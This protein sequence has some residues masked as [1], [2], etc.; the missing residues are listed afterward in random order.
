MRQWHPGL[1][2]G[3]CG[4]RAGEKEVVVAELKPHLAGRGTIIFRFHCCAPRAPR[5]RPVRSQLCVGA[6]QQESRHL[7]ILGAITGRVNTRCQALTVHWVK[8]WILESFM[9]TL[10]VQH[11]GDFVLTNC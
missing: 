6:Q 1:S 8:L 4:G 7:W 11:I 10:A 5:A 2:A 3:V 9:H